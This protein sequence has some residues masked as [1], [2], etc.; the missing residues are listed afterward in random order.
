MERLN[1][2]VVIC[3]ETLV[4]TKEWACNAGIAQTRAIVLFSRY[5]KEY[6]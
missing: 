2:I 5:E 3:G 1:L 4:S 6:Y